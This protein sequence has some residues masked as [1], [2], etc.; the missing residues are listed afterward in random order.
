MLSCRD[1]QNKYSCRRSPRPV[2][3][4]GCT[5]RQALSVAAA[6]VGIK[7]RRPIKIAGHD[8]AAMAITRTADISSQLITRRLLKRRSVFELATDYRRRTAQYIVMTN[9][10]VIQLNCT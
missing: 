10:A 1:R 8:A 9:M 5:A 6:L 4:S 7:S 3:I 2:D